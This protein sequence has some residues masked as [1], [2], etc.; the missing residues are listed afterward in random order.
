MLQW[1]I[2][3]H[4]L[5][6]KYTWKISR[7]ATDYK[8]N[9]IVTVT[10]GA[11]T[12]QGEAAPNIRYDETP[13]RLLEEFESFKRNAPQKVNDLSEIKEQLNQFS[14]SAALSF[15]IESASVHYHAKRNRI[16]VAESFNLNT[17][18]NCGT[19]YTIPM[20]E[21]GLIRQ[22]Y[23]DNKLQ[24]FPFIKIK[25]GHEE[26]A[27]VV[28]H[29]SSFVHQPLLVD[30][31]EAYTD[32]DSCIRFLEKINPYKIEFV[33]QPMPSHL[34]DEI[35]YVKKYS[36]LPLVA[37]ESIT[38][39]ADFSFL[40]NAFDGI[41]VKLMKTG[42]YFKA[43]EYLKKARELKMR[44]MIGCMVET[45]LGIQSAYQLLSLAD[46]ADLDSFLIVKEEPFQYVVEENGMLSLNAKKSL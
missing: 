23:S 41:N 3:T 38:H 4:R 20:M 34:T 45:T 33:E 44:T 29:L 5:D 36:K 13:E 27:E 32:A 1:S 42:S 35:L 43:I 21:T 30:A 28:K 2:T 11:V 37:D 7:N 14:L 31:N 40:K 22:F 39:D 26:G 16:S 10:D 8:V 46:Y 18:S 9:L 24:R 17:V 15:A 19:A 12:A 6:L 25:I